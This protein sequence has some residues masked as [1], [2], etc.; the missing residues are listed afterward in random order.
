MKKEYKVTRHIVEGNEEEREIVYQQLANLFINMALKE[1]EVNTKEKAIETLLKL[2]KYDKIYVVGNE[3]NDFE[4][5]KKYNGYLI[6]KE[7]NNEFNT[8]ECFLD[9]KKKL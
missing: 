1:K 9:L 3:I 8:L 4:M 5:L 6:S 7:N 2:T